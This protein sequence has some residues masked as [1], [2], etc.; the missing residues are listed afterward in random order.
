MHGVTSYAII[1]VFQFLIIF[2]AVLFDLLS[3]IQLAV[4]CVFCSACIR[5]A[6]C[7]PQEGINGPFQILIFNSKITF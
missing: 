2:L 5:F 7:C 4:E 1:T 3:I 6:E